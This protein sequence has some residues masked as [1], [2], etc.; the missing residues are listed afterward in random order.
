[1]SLSKD[2]TITIT[3]EIEGTVLVVKTVSALGKDV[4]NVHGDNSTFTIQ[5]IED[6]LKEIRKFN[7]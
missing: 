7:E 2:L 1:M 6:A 3:N 5:E 4:V